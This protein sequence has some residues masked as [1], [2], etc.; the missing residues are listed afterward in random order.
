MARISFGQITL[1]DP[2]K[3]IEE[4]IELYKSLFFNDSESNQEF[5]LPLISL[6]DD[7][8][9]YDSEILETSEE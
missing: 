2:N 1:E 3:S 7:S 8:D 9:D 6:T 4:L 5:R